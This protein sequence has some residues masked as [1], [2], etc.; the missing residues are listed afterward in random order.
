[1]GELMKAYGLIILCVLS[2]SC[3][4]MSNRRY[5]EEMEH[6]TDGFFVA[7]RDF[8]VAS[9]DSGIVGRTRQQ[10]FQRTP[11]SSV[12]KQRFRDQV[13][14]EEE[15]IDL[16][17]S[18]SSHLRAHY[19]QFVD[20]LTS[21]SEKIYFLKLTSMNEREDYLRSLGL[22]HD[23]YIANRNDIIHAIRQRDLILGMSKNDVA[24]S[25]GRPSRVDIAG[26]PTYENE[27]WSFYERGKLRQVYFENGRV[28]GWSVD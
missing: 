25:W 6:D 20:G 10:I 23:N 18:Q 13:S 5:V 19:E 27:R 2:S 7:G 14:L 21:I 8:K 4:L 22:I 16:E 17:S 26:N 28:E 11:S 9:G 1:M 12:E 3:S 24:E 15:L